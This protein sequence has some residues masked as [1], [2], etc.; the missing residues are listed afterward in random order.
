MIRALIRDD[1][2]AFL[3]GARHGDLPD[4]WDDALAHEVALALA[5]SV[6]SAGKTMRA[7]WELGAR[8]PGI[9]SSCAA[10]SSTPGKPG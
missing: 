9:G 10:G 4:A 5:A 7:A 3:G 2:P 6:P 8:L 1:D